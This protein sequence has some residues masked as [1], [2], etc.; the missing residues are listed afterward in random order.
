MMVGGCSRNLRVVREG[1]SRRW[2]EAV[3]GTRCSEGGCSRN[4]RVVMEGFSRRWEE[5]VVGTRGWWG[6]VVAGD[7][8][9]L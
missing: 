7:G 5:A 2:M 1:C 4:L 3:S 6:R 8:R 9:M